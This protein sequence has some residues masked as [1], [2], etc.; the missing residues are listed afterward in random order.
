VIRV[1]NEEGPGGLVAEAIRRLG[2]ALEGVNPRWAEL[3]L[4][5]MAIAMFRRPA[6]ERSGIL[7]I[8]VRE[9]PTREE[10]IRAMEKTLAES[11]FEQGEERGNLQGS[12]REA[13]RALLSL[14]RSRLGGE[15][16]E[17]LAQ[18]IEAST[19]VKELDDAFDRALTL[20][21]LTGFA[22]RE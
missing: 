5:L 6:S 21:D 8:M 14:L 9:N 15:C 20:T 4:S 22:L 11:L 18:Q 10:V 16:P 3:I 13:R 19:S 7:E 1:S 12:L 2:P 17:Q